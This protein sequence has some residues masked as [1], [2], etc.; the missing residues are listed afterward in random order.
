MGL[1]KL[2][3][4]HPKV[5][6]NTNTEAQPSSNQYISSAL[7]T[8]VSS[9]SAHPHIMQNP[10]PTTVPASA[11]PPPYHDWTIVPDTST[12]PPP[13]AVGHEASPTGNTSRFQ[14]DRAHD[15]CRANHLLFP[16]QPLPVHTDAVRNGDIGLIRPQEYRGDL[17]PDRIGSW[18]GSTKPGVT[19]SLVLTSLP[20]YFAWTDSPT[21]TGKTK[22]IYFE[23]EIRNMVNVG[24]N[25]ESAIAL[26]YCALPQPTWRMPGWERATL[27][28][29]SDDG[30]R[31]VNN[32]WGG[33][34][35]TKSF[36]AGDTVGVGMTFTIP[37]NPPK[38]NIDASQM[39]VQSKVDV[40]FTRNGKRDGNW[41]LHEE[42]DHEKD[43]PIDG[44]D[45]LFD[46][47]GAIGIFG[48]VEFAIKFR[49]EDWLWRPH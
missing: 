5:V 31:Y 47:Y 1:L 23:I 35:F 36:K 27:G 26:G 7:N 39:Q 49:R 6:G 18:K 42:L 12:L 17:V 44:L 41:D 11:D 20:L 25:D 4:K 33:K 46:L 14:A 22:T 19:E 3:G 45:G 24:G 30:R 32:T 38:Y 8:T 15:W 21:H 48:A 29:H 10:A 34:D 16:H 13:P 2:K 40:F 9:N 28:V 37:N 43:Q